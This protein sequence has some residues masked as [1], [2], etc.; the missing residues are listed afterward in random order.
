MRES[1]IHL[2]LLGVVALAGSACGGVGEDIPAAT[3]VAPTVVTVT[4]TDFAFEAPDSVVEGWTTV[5]LVNAGGRFH[6]AL[7]VRL[8]PE[9]RLQ[10][11]RTAYAEAWRASGPW[12]GFGFRGGL[13]SAPPGGSVNVTLLLE[14]GRY[15]WY[16]PM[17]VEGGAPHVF[18]QD[19]AKTLVVAERPS[20]DGV[21]VPP[22]ATARIELLD[23]AFGMDEAWA[24]GP[25]VIRVDN[26]GREVHEVLLFRLAPGK[27]LEDALG[28]SVDPLVEN[29][30]SDY[31]GGAVVEPEDSEVYFETE[32]TPGD[33][34]L[35]CSIRAPDGRVH[36]EHG[37]IRPVRVS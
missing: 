14:P 37:M 29:P 19:M 18:E 24:A 26:L 36:T 11:F 10:D 28:W 15:A 12:D 25:H 34:V 35:V 4:A 21:P 33:Y 7:L 27:S 16:C 8:G 5:R 22:V 1:R 30:F 3:A 20:S 31:L 17:H 13:V 32:L 23:Y 2:G 9:E 6:A